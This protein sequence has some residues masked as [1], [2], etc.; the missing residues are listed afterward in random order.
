MEKNMKISVLGKNDK[1]SKKDIKHVLNFVC[2]ILLGKRLCNNISI[3]VI[4]SKFKKHEWGYCGPTDYY[5][6]NYREFEIL[7]NC[8][9]SKR[10]QIITILHEA[11]H[12]KQYAR[13]EF[14]CHDTKNF[15]WLG[16]K[17]TVELSDYEN[18]PWEIEARSAEEI[19]YKL[20]M[21]YVKL[22]QQ[23]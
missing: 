23:R 11:V 10:N 3:T 6:R 18:L 13:R 21:D 15:R 7:L 1:L 5:N 20:Y 9:A 8:T 22:C 2:D 19:L 14:L 12:V 16:K 17:V 4:N